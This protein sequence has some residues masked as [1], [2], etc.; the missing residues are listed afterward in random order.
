MLV[1]SLLQHDLRGLLHPVT[2]VD[3]V[4]PPGANAKNLP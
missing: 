2:D 3:H 1:T 4:A